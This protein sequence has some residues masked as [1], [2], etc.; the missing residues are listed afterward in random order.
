MRTPVAAL[1]AL[2]VAVGVPTSACAQAPPSIR[3]VF[4]NALPSVAVIRAAGSEVS[5]RTG[6][7][8]RFRET[9]AGALISDD[10]KVM[11]A[12]H[13]VHAMEQII[14]EFLGSELVPARVI[15]SEPAADVSIIQ[16]ER[17]PSAAR[18]APMADSD[19]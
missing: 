7:V 19:K 15:S 2:S 16:L 13:V 12:A 11:T 17:V 3:D 5:A 6:G 4:R 1:F 9:G 18:A 14:V 10:G 8:S